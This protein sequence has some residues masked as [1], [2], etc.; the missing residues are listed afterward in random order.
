MRDRCLK[1]V[2]NGIWKREFPLSHLLLTT[3]T[4]ANFA[5]IGAFNDCPGPVPQMM[6]KFNPGSS[7]DLRD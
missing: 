5:M 1:N 4:Q 7:Q 6:V 3:S 2:G